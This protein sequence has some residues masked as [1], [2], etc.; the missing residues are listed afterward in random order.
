MRLF[1]KAAARRANKE[2][3]V[4]TTPGRS[5]VATSREI[6][7][8]KRHHCAAKHRTYSGMARCIYRM[9]I[10]GQGSYVTFSLSEHGEQSIHLHQTE[11][12]ARNAVA[13]IE[14][15]ECGGGCNPSYMDGHIVR[16]ELPARK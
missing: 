7:A 3:V 13:G 16:L 11:E 14:D 9:R 10:Y 4:T 5:A 12:A 2:A 1:R 6:F 8:C 15:S